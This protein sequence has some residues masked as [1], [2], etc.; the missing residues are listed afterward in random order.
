[1]R[2]NII[3]FTTMFIILSSTAFAD[4]YL[5]NTTDCPTC[6]NGAT[7][8]DPTT[9]SVG[10]GSDTVYIS[11]DSFSSNIAASNVNYIRSGTY[12]RSTNSTNVGALSIDASGTAGSKTEVIAYTGEQPT[13]CPA[14]D[15][16][17]TYC[18]YNPNPGDTSVR[19]CSGGSSSGGAVCYYPNPAVNI[20]GSYIRLSG[21]K[22]YGQV[23][24]GGVHDYIIE[25]GD[26][27]GGGPH[28]NQGAVIM[29]DTT[30]SNYNGVIRNNRIHHSAWGESNSNGAAII[31]YNTS[32][33]IE[34][35]EF[36]DNWYADI[37]PKDASY[38]LG[39]TTYIRH[40]I[41]RSSSIYGS[42]TGVYSSTQDQDI[43]GYEIHNNIFIG[44]G[45]G[46][47]SVNP[48]FGLSVVYNNTFIDCD[49]DIF[50][51][52]NGAPVNSYNNLFYHANGGQRYYW[53]DGGPHGAKTNANFNLYFSGSGTTYW[54]S[55]SSFSTWQGYGLDANSLTSNIVTFVNPAGSTPESFKR[56]S[57]I[58][59]LSSS[60]YGV[61]AG[62]Y[63][64]G[65]EQIGVVGAAT[66]LTAP[67][68]S[69][70]SVKSNTVT[71]KFDEPVVTTGYDAGDFD[72]DCTSAGQNISLTSP[73]GSGSSRTFTL[74]VSVAYG[75]TCNLDYTGSTDDIED[76][77]GNDLA[78][79]SNTN[80]TV[81]TA[82]GSTNVSTGTDL[83]IG[84]ESTLTWSTP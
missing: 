56:T 80:V 23:F 51:W 63:E 28:I 14:D 76:T 75:D 3:L 78:T 31:M 36:Y 67:T 68:V 84:S 74:A 64:T 72:M 58:E 53:F 37:V 33:T 11:L 19:E 77:A 57:Y 47:Y 1:M 10:G 41:F 5:D 20:G 59:N 16:G 43:D 9:R 34:N 71:I 32:V 8:Y 4:V 61:H 79:F 12:T 30:G 45:T 44:K 22:T 82:Q 48:D 50:T 73:S 46:V 70:A 26:F 39:R 83:S 54:N 40:N 15:S 60:P 24:V 62:A 27:G 69:S 55:A 42:S 49:R 21:I 35:N 13:I 6:T 52:N 65:S 25:N 29:L 17:N 66:D 7:T 18:Q 38:Q 81:N 2:K